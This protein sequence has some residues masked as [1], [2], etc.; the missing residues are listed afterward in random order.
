MDKLLLLNPFELKR[1]DQKI[2]SSYNSAAVDSEFCQNQIPALEEIKKFN[3]RTGIKPVIATSLMTDGGLK[4]WTKFF[5]DLSNTGLSEEVIVNDFGILSFVMGKFKICIGRIM[6]RDF[7]KM[8]LTWAQKFLSENGVTGI[9]AD[10]PQLLREIKK[11]KLNISWHKGYSLIAPTT[12]CPFERHFRAFC[13]KTCLKERPVLKNSDVG[14]SLTLVEKAY[15]KSEKRAIPSGVSRTIETL[16][17]PL[18]SPTR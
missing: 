5:R 11:F 18:P 2:L 10:T 7:S 12:F 6:A 15:F 3:S 8:G 1:A 4:L 13:S 17:L 9:E 14:Y 16:S